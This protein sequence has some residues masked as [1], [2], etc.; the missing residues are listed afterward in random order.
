MAVDG[1]NDKFKEATKTIKEEAIKLRRLDKKIREKVKH[2]QSV[3][4]QEKT[5]EY[6]ETFKKLG[7]AY[8]YLQKLNEDFYVDVK[9]TDTPSGFRRTTSY[10]VSRGK[11]VRSHSSRG[12]GDINTRD[13]FNEECHEQTDQYPKK[14]RWG[15][16]KVNSKAHFD[17]QTHIG[18]LQERVRDLEQQLESQR[19]E[20]QSY[21]EHISEL[22]QQVAVARQE[23][24]VGLTRRSSD[25][26]YTSNAEL[27]K[28]EDEHQ[29]HIQKLEQSHQM[30][31]Q[32]FKKNIS[33]LE[34]QVEVKIHEK[35]DA[36][37]RLSHLVSSQLRDNNP[38]IADLSDMYRPTKIAEHYSELYDNEWTDAYGMLE[39]DNTDKEC[40]ETL[41]DVLKK[42]YEECR[43]L[44]TDGFFERVQ[45]CIE[46]PIQEINGSTGKIEMSDFFKQQI[47]E[48][49][50]K[51]APKV[52]G[53]IKKYVLPRIHTEKVTTDTMQ[54]YIDKCIELCW[55]M[56]VQDPPLVLTFK[57]D[58][59]SEFDEKM[60]RF[61]TKRGRHVEYF[62][63]PMLSISGGSMLAKGVA[64]GGS[65][66]Q[67]V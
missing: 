7:E 21:K 17:M 23:K 2:G 59:K 56:V 8:F 11:R 51:G 12:R 46:S 4:I 26:K 47:K 44:A 50:K 60:F 32:S 9:T 31:L 22:K 34:K 19:R 52:M 35:N 61:Y 15:E 53:S 38:N 36:L 14:R 3:T 67:K 66:T 62:V 28:K 1:V 16:N 63:W 33:E 5:K 49:R 58:M 20:I 25:K 48:I 57:S 39:S 54:A 42:I 43:H 40:C 37:T 41:L 30:E 18:E 65:T 29:K 45:Q 64:Q 24:N 13:T 27:R 10:R 55:L 6:D